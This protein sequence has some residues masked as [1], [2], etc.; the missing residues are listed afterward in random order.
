MN[1]TEVVQL[2]VDSDTLNV[3]DFEKQLPAYLYKTIEG[4]HQDLT[5]VVEA[6]ETFIQD[7]VLSFGYT[8]DVSTGE[9]DVEWM[10]NKMSIEISVDTDVSTIFDIHRDVYTKYKSKFTAWLEIQDNME[11]CYPNDIKEF[12]AMLEGR[13]V[14]TAVGTFFSFLI[15]EELDEANFDY[16][17]TKFIEDIEDTLLEDLYM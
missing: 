12:F 7:L 10:F 9:G 14:A 2:R 8:F 6:Y 1:C 15:H 11:L 16:L 5:N 4:Y 13:D 3:F 17:S